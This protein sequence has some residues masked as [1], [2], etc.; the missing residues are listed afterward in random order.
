MFTF[1]NFFEHLQSIKIVCMYLAIPR[2]DSACIKL[3][4]IRFRVEKR[5]RT[6]MATDF[7]RKEGNQSGHL[8]VG[9][10]S[11]SVEFQNL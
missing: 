5:N 7:K 3:L 11:Y 4:G 2:S 10:Q 9:A 6:S 8:D 1:Q